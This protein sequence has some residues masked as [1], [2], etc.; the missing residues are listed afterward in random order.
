M[1][2]KLMTGHT[3]ESEWVKVS[4]GSVSISFWREDFLDAIV[5]L[6]PDNV[7]YQFNTEDDDDTTSEE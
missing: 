7:A 2:L 1:P 5:S 6:Y 3:D 4:L